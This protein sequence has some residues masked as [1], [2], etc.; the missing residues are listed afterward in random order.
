MRLAT[1]STET[2]RKTPPLFFIC[3]I[4]ARAS[5]TELWQYHLLLVVVFMMHHKNAAV[6]SPSEWSCCWNAW[7]TRYHQNVSLDCKVKVHMKAANLNDAFKAVFIRE[8]NRSLLWSLLAMVSCVSLRNYFLSSG[9]SSG[10]H[11]MLEGIV[12]NFYV[13]QFYWLVTDYI[14]FTN[15]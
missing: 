1:T 8:W 5:T 15:L 6:I 12:L 9:R 3:F 14:T 10:R 2:V 13:L 7:V 11:A 4:L